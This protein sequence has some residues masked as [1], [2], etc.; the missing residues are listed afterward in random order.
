MELVAHL[1]RKLHSAFKSCVNASLQEEALCIIRE[2]GAVAKTL[3]NAEFLARK[4]LHGS[5]SRFRDY[6]INLQDNRL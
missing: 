4:I 5:H 6:T 1:Y 3:Q 2:N